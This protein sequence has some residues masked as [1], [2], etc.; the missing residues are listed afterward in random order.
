MRSALESLTGIATGSTGSLVTGTFLQYNGLKGQFVADERVW[1]TKS[2]HPS[3]QPKTLSFLSDKVLCIVRNPLDVIPSFGTMIN[4][5]SHSAML[6][7]D[8]QTEFPEW[9]DWF[10]KY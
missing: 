10:V 9:W 5:V 1:I 4:T 3:S 2:H 7:Y 6:D 8:L